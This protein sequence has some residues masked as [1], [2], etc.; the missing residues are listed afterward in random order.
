M[1]KNS[2][3]S[4][5][6]NNGIRSYFI[7]EFLGAFNDNVL[8]WI[9][10]SFAMDSGNIKIVPTISIIFVLPF[11]LFSGYGGY[12]A[13]KYSKK[14]VLIT[15]K[16]L[17][18]IIM[19]IC[20][21]ILY[22]ASF[23]PLLALLFFMT[24]QSALFGPAKFSIIPEICD[25][26]DIP[27]L[28]GLVA[29][30][31]FIAIC[32]G[33][34]TGGWLHHLFKD[35]LQS[36]AYFMLIIS[37]I[38]LVCSFA[39][40]PTQTKNP[41]KVF[42][43]NPFKGIYESIQM[44]KRR[45]YLS[46]ALIGAIWFWFL[47][48]MLSVSF[49]VYAKQ[50][51]LLH[52]GAT[53]T[54]NLYLCI[55]VGIGGLLSG[56]LCH[57]RIEMGIVP[58]GIFI[59]SIGALI[60]ALSSFYAFSV[61][62]LA[63][64]G[65]GGGMFVVPL[66]SFLQ[67]RS[68]MNIKGQ[69]MAGFN[70]FTFL[71][72]IAAFIFFKVLILF[73]LFANNMHLV[74][75]TFAGISIF[76]CLYTIKI[77]PGVFVRF[78]L[79]ILTHCL[80]KIKVV[81]AENLPRKGPVLFVSNH[82]SYIDGLLI[83]GSMARELRF[84][85]LENYYFAPI[86]HWVLKLVKAIPTYRSGKKIKQSIDMAKAALDRG[87]QVCLFAEGYITQTGNIL[88]FKR[89]FEK[90]IED[91]NIPIIPVH[92]DRV[93]GSMF[94]FK[95]GKMQTKMPSIFPCPITVSFGEP[96]KNDT[97][98]HQLREK[99]I[100]LGHH[101]INKR[102]EKNDILPR[103][104]F[105]TAK[106]RFF[107]KCIADSL[108]RDLSFGKTLVGSIILSKQVRSFCENEEQIGLMLPPS[109]GGAIANI[110]S[111]IAGKVAVNM[112]VTAGNEA[113]QSVI[114][115]CEIK[116]IFTSRKLWERL[117]IDVKADRIVFLEDIMGVITPLERIVTL[118][119][120]V[121]LPYQLLWWL[122]GDGKLNSN[123]TATI[124][125]SSGTTGVPKGVILTHHNLV[126][127]IEQVFQIFPLI[128]GKDTIAGSLPFFHSF[129]Y[130]VTIWLPL[131]IG[132]RGVYHPNPL[133]FKKVGDLIQKYQATFM[134]STPTFYQKY[135]RVCTKEQLSSIEYALAG[136]EKL[137]ENISHDFT[138]KFDVEILEGYG[139]TEMGPVV[140]VNRPDVDGQ[141]GH[142]PGSVGQ[143]LP[144]ILY[145]IVD[146][147]TKQDIEGKPGLL[148][149]KSPAQMQNYFKRADKNHII[150]NGWYN[151][152]DIAKVDEKGFLYLTDRLARFSKIGGEMVPHIKIEDEINKILG[153]NAST[154]VSIA[155][156][157]KGEKVCAIYHH[158]SLTPGELHHRLEQTQLPKLWIPRS[159][160]IHLVDELPIMINGKAD[161]V[162]AK[163][164]VVNRSTKV[165]K[166]S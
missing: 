121:L 54:L 134:V 77:I 37:I 17:E 13:D 5:L 114:D 19:A 86:L 129:G 27:R 20:T 18:V 145:R 71:G 144:G 150:D 116:T 50:I 154:I 8:R 107:K 123:S 38:G 35:N 11:L 42:E 83:G 95:N 56:R 143:L 88:P 122:H 53:A 45:K 62:G 165:E 100:E 51:L 103:L 28:N 148:L 43:I 130:T 14:D 94:S 137:R 161:L 70:F 69:A 136:A 156:E 91:R 87:E 147:E 73:D 48:G 7:T 76:S 66:N 49:P 57:G 29:A 158:P 152:G 138:K 55:G 31:N 59:L 160:D 85:V 72:A 149:L 124:I 24:L 84:M 15:M 162:K 41:N 126:S 108:G 151:T 65:F 12:L 6:S 36:P 67:Q 99:I 164:M 159:K 128:P 125:F 92:L 133:E 115:Q 75:F 98:P 101:A 10:I 81:G 68:P 110:A 64:I 82:V 78:I 9:L 89:G 139:C 166:K 118:L 25:E 141:K 33:S 142:I 26:K 153:E 61:L 74:Y 120:V 21:V 79:W 104:F 117:N 90:I 32:I 4:L 63:L 93:W 112:N 132:L 140:S 34:F 96:L 2:Y 102:R 113:M 163:K 131:I 40:T 23:F 105:K 30:G 146:P 22:H 39:I 80:Y 47:S 157:S 106:S 1:S 109:V 3:Y 111:A 60:M 127:N 58:V 135:T 97:T 119:Q 155:D 16:A 44:Y 46:I 52:E